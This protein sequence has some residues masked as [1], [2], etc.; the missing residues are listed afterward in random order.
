MQEINNKIIELSFYIQAIS[1]LVYYTLCTYRY[2]P[3]TQEQL[4]DQPID[5]LIHHGHN[6][7][8][9]YKKL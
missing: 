5:T 1:L 4:H 9:A 8:C 3:L 2:I 6:Q 7:S